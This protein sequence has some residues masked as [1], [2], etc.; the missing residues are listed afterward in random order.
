MKRSLKK[1]EKA[2]SANIDA[3]VLVCVTL[4]TRPEL[5]TTATAVRARMASIAHLA[6]RAPPPEGAP[7]ARTTPPSSKR[8]APTEMT[9]SGRREIV[10]PHVISQRPRKGCGCRCPQRHRDRW[11]QRSPQQA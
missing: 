10:S 4:A 8:H 1:I 5:A 3:K 11:G 7:E 6:G 2:S 9:I